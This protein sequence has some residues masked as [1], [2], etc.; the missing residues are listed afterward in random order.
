MFGVIQ[1][2]IC[3]NAH[4][5]QIGVIGISSNQL[6]EGFDAFSKVADFKIFIGFFNQVLIFF[7]DIV[8][9]DN[10]FILNGL[11]GTLVFDTNPISF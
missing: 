7:G 6:I 3:F 9:I 8:T 11:T 4:I 1:L 5:K 10:E 2:L